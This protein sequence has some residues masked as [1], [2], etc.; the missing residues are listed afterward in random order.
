MPTAPT[1]PSQ[2]E[3]AGKAHASADSVAAFND[4]AVVAAERVQTALEVFLAPT[5]PA[6]SLR[7]RHSDANTEATFDALYALV[8]RGGKRWRAALGMLGAETGALSA[9]GAASLGVALELLQGYFL[10]HD[11][12]MDQDDVRR[13]GPSVHAALRSQFASRSHSGVH[14]GDASAILAGDCAC[15]LAQLALSGADAEPR[16]AVGALRAFAEMQRDVVVGQTLDV[17]GDLPREGAWEHIYTVYRLKTGSYTVTGPLVLGAILAGA[18]AAC[19]H[20]LEAFGDPLGIAFQIAD[21]LLGTFGESAVTGKSALGDLREGKRTAVVAA[22]ADKPEL[23]A[24]FDKLRHGQGLGAIE[25]AAC[26]D[27]LGRSGVQE[28]LASRI[29]TLRSMATTALD[30]A[31]ISATVASRLRGAATLLSERKV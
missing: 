26:V 25:A 15:A 23:S 8:L 4:F 7:A 1:T 9:S 17:V 29:A 24:Y 2:T 6:R 13:G 14:L 3:R 28:E 16:A 18:P 5:G 31:P 20:A 10:V 27:A 12:W 21:D 19:M 22:M 11:D 30:A